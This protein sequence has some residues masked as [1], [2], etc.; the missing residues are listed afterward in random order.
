MHSNNKIVPKCHNKTKSGA[1][2]AAPSRKPPKK[3]ESLQCWLARAPD[4]LHG[5]NKKRKTETRNGVSKA[6]GLAPPVW[7]G[8][9]CD[10]C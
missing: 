5:I 1:L 6:N 7:A 10:I 9:H 8:G 3:A 4:K 2:R